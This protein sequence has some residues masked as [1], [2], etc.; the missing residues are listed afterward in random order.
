[1][2]KI[3]WQTRSPLL[4]SC[5]NEKRLNP[6][7]NGG[8]A[9]D[10]QAATSLLEKFKVIPDSKAVYK[11]NDNI[12]SYWLR[13]SNHQP[14]AEIKVMEPYPIVF[15][16]IPRKGT[17]I[18]MIHHI[19]EGLRQKSLK[20]K[21]F[22]NRLIK[23]LKK[24]ERVVTVSKYWKNYLEKEG[25]ENVVIIYNSFDLSKYY[26]STN[27]IADFRHSLG[28]EKNK[29]LIYIGNASNR[30]GVQEA[31]EALK[32]L[33]YQLVMTGSR[34]VSK[35]L[36]VKFL[37]LPSR[38]YR[39][40]IS[41]C[42]VVLAMSQMSEGWNRIAHEAMLCKVPVIGSGSGGMKEL[43][44]GGEQFISKNFTELPKLVK[45]SLENKNKLGEKGYKFVLRFD[46]NYFKN[47]WQSILE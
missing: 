37:S 44:Q 47:S 32:D 10:F 24:L 39:M 36:D 31:Y 29:P 9:Y 16:S 6:S 41:S 30:K 19:D 5:L 12:L 2:K 34:N 27:D 4:F 40:L 1:M 33:P 25:C 21:W 15:G 14:E 7:A 18:A 42:D 43:L 38:E 13:L 20:H 35:H 3:A 11:I 23:R 28:F 46:L 26:F 8:N 45:N 17:D 22:Y